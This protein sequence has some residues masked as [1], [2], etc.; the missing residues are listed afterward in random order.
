MLLAYVAEQILFSQKDSLL[1]YNSKKK[2]IQVFSLAAFGCS[3]IRSI[4]GLPNLLRE[5]M[6]CIL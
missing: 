3:V 1:I 4:W 5:E 6:G 2:K